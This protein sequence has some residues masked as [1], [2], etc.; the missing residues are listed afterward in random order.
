[1][2][3]VAGIR[4]AR[5]I[6]K[7]LP[8]T[9]QRFRL[10]QKLPLPFKSEM[11]QLVQS[12]KKIFRALILIDVIFVRAV[13]EPRGAPVIPRDDIASTRCS[14]DTSSAVYPAKISKQRRFQ[15][16]KSSTQQKRVNAIV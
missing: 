15:F 11:R 13:A 3:D 9:G 12:D 14:S 16:R 1:M 8:G 7:K 5:H 10:S 4:C 6:Q 2:A